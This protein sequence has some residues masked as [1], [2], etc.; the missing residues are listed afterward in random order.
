MMRS[1]H[2]G[3]NRQLASPAISAKAATI[4]RPVDFHGTARSTNA[5]VELVYRALDVAL[6][7]ALS[8]GGIQVALDLGR[9]QLLHLDLIMR[10]RAGTT[11]PSPATT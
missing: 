1:Y 11:D 4:S 9:N 10:A 3:R 5:Q 7:R 6:L 8:R 2:R